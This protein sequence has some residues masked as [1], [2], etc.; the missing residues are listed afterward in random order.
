MNNPIDT[1]SPV[2]YVP[3]Q[4]QNPSTESLSSLGIAV[5]TSQAD[6]GQN[7]DFWSFDKAYA[8]DKHDAD[9]V[10]QPVDYALKSAQIGIKDAT[11]IFYRG[12][13]IRT[14]TRGQAD[15][16]IFPDHP[17]KTL[18]VAAGSDWNSWTS[19]V[20]TYTGDTANI[21]ALQET[22]NKLPIRS[23]VKNT[24]TDALNPRSFNNAGNTWSDT[25]TTTAGTYLID[26]VEVDTLV[27]SDGIKG[28]YVD[29]MIFGLIRS[30]AESLTLDSVRASLR[31]TRGG[32]RRVGR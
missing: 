3:F 14:K 25:T 11:R 29:I 24:T 27:V 19:Q 21:A 18:N 9:D 6:G 10:A 16:P 13:A 1:L 2:L 7:M 28:E 15:A 4:I 5:N 20:V 17:W 22:L 26:E 8:D 12:V 30:R 23:R 31:N 32:R